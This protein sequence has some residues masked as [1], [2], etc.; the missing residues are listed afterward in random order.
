MIAP[1][2]RSR[3]KDAEFNIYF[4]PA[5]EGSEL[6]SPV[7]K[8]ISPSNSNQSSIG[9]TTSTEHKKAHT[10]VSQSS[11][12]SSELPITLLLSKALSLCYNP[13]GS[14]SFSRGHET[15]W[16]ELTSAKLIVSGVETSHAMITLEEDPRTLAGIPS[17]IDFAILVE[18]P[19]SNS[20]SSSSSTLPSSSSIPTN[21]PEHKEAQITS[22]N[23][24]PPL[25]PLVTQDLSRGF[26]VDFTFESSIGLVSHMGSGVRRYLG[27]P[28]EWRIGYDGFTQVGKID[29]K[30]DLEADGTIAIK[31]D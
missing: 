4:F 6:P 25:S 13:A 15:S 17:S 27:S 30:G 22:S 5:V 8:A 12:I 18:L 3:V 29:M 28:R 11:T 1:T 7:I 23:S 24:S 21:N 20:T 2:A 16:T 31:K 19:L 14:L 9:A 26:E 10:A